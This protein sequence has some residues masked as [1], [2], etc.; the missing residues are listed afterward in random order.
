MWTTTGPIYSLCYD[1]IHGG[2][3]DRITEPG[4]GLNV[5]SQEQAFSPVVNMLTLLGLNFHLWLLILSLLPVQIMEGNT[6]GSKDM[7]SF[8]MWDLD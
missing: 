3:W 6:D 5:F 4:L 7:G 8:Y 1:H 2:P